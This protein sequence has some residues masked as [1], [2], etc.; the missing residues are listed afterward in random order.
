MSERATDREAAKW[1]R[2]AADSLND[3]IQQAFIY[4]VETEIDVFSEV[5][6]MGEI[7]HVTVKTRKL[8]K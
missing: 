7:S 2:D 1:V 4:G 8:L 5:S 3:A 6:M